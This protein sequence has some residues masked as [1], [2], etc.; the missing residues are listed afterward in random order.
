MAEV[1][2]DAEGKYLG[3]TDDEAFDRDDAYEHGAGAF[4]WSKDYSILWIMIPAG[5]HPQ[6]YCLSPWHI[7]PNK[8]DG[9]HSWQWDGNIEKPTL[10]PSLHAVGIWHG[11]MRNGN[12]V[13]V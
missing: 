7:K 9:G 13:S 6:G 1:K 12:L 5:T 8:N 4:F 2:L 3:C 10:T 11:Y